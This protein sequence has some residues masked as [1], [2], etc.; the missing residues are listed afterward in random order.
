MNDQQTAT[1][2]TGDSASRA[3]DPTKTHEV[4]D[5]E[6][7]V[8]LTCCKVDPTGRYVFAGAE[9]ENVYRWD[10]ATGTR[11]TFTGH[12]SWVRS[13]EFSSDGRW[14]YTGGWDGQLGYWTTDA[15]QPKPMHMLQAHRGFARWVTRSP[16]GRMLA[17]CG[18]DLFVRIWDEATGEMMTE[19][20]EHTRH[21]YAVCFHPTDGT[22]VSEDMT[23]KVIIRDVRINPRPETIQTA[24][25]GYDKVFAADM[26]GARDM[27]FNTDGSLLAC[28]GITNVVNAFAGQQDPIV[29]VI[30]WKTRKVTHHLQAK[31]KKTGVMW[32]VRFHPDGF[33]VGAVGQQSGKGELLFWRLGEQPAE[34]DKQAKTEDKDKPAEIKSFHSLGLAKSVR[35]IDF[36]PD[37]R[38]IDAV[39]SDG[40]LRIY[41][42]SEK[43]AAAG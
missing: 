5:F 25:T 1:P 36:T 19:M 7:D 10:I 17:T 35:G 6:F 37:N 2:P 29:A 20:R 4:A 14:L 22:L 26:G 41:E 34:S 16:C 9:D 15:D 38:R 32:G 12:E 11:T 43:Q 33:V 13:I 8:A 3:L 40:H 27:Q 30:D 24:M 39:H 23:G 28:A 42:M 18:N 21:P 31:D